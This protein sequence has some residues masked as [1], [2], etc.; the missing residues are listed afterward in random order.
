MLS[1][2]I[3]IG[4]LSLALTGCFQGVKPEVSLLSA[5]SGYDR[6][7][8]VLSVNINKLSDSQV[9]QVDTIVEIVGPI[10]K[11]EVTDESTA[12]LLDRVESYVLELEGL[13]GSI[14]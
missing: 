8:R 2:F 11:G 9:E 12:T 10:C 6:A 14:E 4:V 3:G 7:L 1:K 5:C 13:E